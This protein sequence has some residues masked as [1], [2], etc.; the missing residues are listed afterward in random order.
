MTESTSDS[1]CC[2]K[3]KCRCCCIFAILHIAILT[4][5]SMALWKVADAI[6]AMAPAVADLLA[7]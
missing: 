7:K 3:K 5:I 4:C 2:S 1:S 6:E